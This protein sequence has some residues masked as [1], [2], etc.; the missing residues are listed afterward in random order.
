MIRIY[1]RKKFERELS[2]ETKLLPVSALVN[3]NQETFVYLVEEGKCRKTSVTTGTYG[4]GMVEIMEGLE[5]GAEV[6]DSPEEYGLKDGDECS[7]AVK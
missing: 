4:G 6:V 3:E 5:A 2:G 7:Y 1:I